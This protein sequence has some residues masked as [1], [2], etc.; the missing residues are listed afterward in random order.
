MK[1]PSKG[2]WQSALPGY[3]Q[4]LTCEPRTSPVLRRYGATHVN[5]DYKAMGIMSDM[6]GALRTLTMAAVLVNA[7]AAQKNELRNNMMQN[8]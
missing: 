1:R 3:Q 7:S 4:Q 2:Y 8:M 5:V 6:A